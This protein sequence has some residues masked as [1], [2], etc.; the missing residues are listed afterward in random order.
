MS[1]RKHYT[2]RTLA[3]E[4]KLRKFFL[5][6]EIEQLE[7]LGVSTVVIREY[8]LRRKEQKWED[9]EEILAHKRVEDSREVCELKKEI[10][11]ICNL[12]PNDPMFICHYMHLPH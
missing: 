5:S 10:A 12:F 8:A 1:L 11:E 3:I 9:W 7:N 2:K 4:R 6:E